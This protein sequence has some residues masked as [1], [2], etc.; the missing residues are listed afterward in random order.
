MSNYIFLKGLASSVAIAA[1][2]IVAVFA[3][4]KGTEVSVQTGECETV[5]CRQDVAVAR[6]ATAAYHD[7]NL[8]LADGYVQDS[9][10]VRRAGVGTMGFHFKNAALVDQIADVAQP[11]LLLYLPNEEGEMELVAVEYVVPNVGNPV[12]YLFGKAFHYSTARNRYELHAWIW[13]NNPAGMFEDFNPSLN[14]PGF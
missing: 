13:R 10:C 7:I 12:P 6:R 8:A 4:P 14:C 3:F 11:E 9:P 5:E 1:F 2:S